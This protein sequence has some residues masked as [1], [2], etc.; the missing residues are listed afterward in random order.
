M[1]LYMQYENQKIRDDRS[2]GGDNIPVGVSGLV[3][4]EHE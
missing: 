3:Q 4:S 2:I 1:N